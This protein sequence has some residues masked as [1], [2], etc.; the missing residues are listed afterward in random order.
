MK[1]IYSVKTLCVLAMMGTVTTVGAQ[2]NKTDKD[3]NLNREMTLER[4]YDPSVQ[5]ANKVNTLPVVKEPVVRKIPIDYATFTVPADP[6]KE[7]GL[8][9][10]GNIMT[11]MAYNKRRGYFNFGAGTYLNLNG[12]IGYHILS[13]DKDKLDVWY[14]HRSTN[15]KV[16]YIQEDEKVKAKLNDNLAGINF[17]HNFEKLSLLLGAKYGYSAFNYY[18]L[19]MVNPVQSIAPIERYEPDRTTNQVNQTIQFNAGVESKENAPFGYL[20]DLGYTNF[21]HKYA[22][23][24]D[25]KGPTENTFDV[26]FDLNA[27]FGGNQ[28]IG[29]G[30]NFEYFNYSLPTNGTQEYLFFEN[31]AEGRVSPYYKVEGDNWNLKLGVNVMFVTGG[32]S[33]MMVSPDVAFDMEVADKTVLYAIAG[34]KLYS[35]SMYD[36]SLI[37][38]YMD[39]TEEITPSRNWLD[40]TLGIKSGVANGFWFDVF[41]GYKI[42][43]DDVLFLPS[44]FYREGEFGNYTKPMGGI[45]TKHFFAGANLKYNYQ[46]LDI[47]LKGVYNNRKAKYGSSWDGASGDLEHA[48]GKPEMEINAGVSVHPFKPLTVA[49]DYYLATGRYVELFGYKSVKMDN[50]NELNLTGT[51]NFNDTF[52]VYVKLNNVL[53]QKYEVLYGYPLQSFSA[54]VGV[55]INF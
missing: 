1:T 21:S 32:D 19:P 12:D 22:L 51:Y 2:E 7:I 15:G 16:K 31:H 42:T 52:G 36:M 33:K 29:L 55:N 39:P 9:P 46:W 23:S 40:A 14:S 49:L 18:G 47:S 37:N 50:I 41:A 28:K 43:S 44:R 53:F 26:K 35:N 3:K 48:W 54:M 11:Q 8:L 10:S 27:G 17:R 34:G 4:E 45:D 5:D 6:A 30:G 13:T 24:K 20:L 38:R 25:Q